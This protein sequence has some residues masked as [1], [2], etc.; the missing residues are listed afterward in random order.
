MM[1]ANPKYACCTFRGSLAS[2]D[3]NTGHLL[4][5][6]YTIPDPPTT[7]KKNAQAPS[8]MDR[9]RSNLVVTHHRR[10]AQKPLCGHGE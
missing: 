7:T 2:L 6:T 9:R 10:Q 3:A 4:G 5:K 1:A 8:Y